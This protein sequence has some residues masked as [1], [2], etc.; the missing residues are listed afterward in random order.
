LNLYVEGVHATVFAHIQRCPLFAP[1]KF[2]FSWVWLVHK[3]PN[4]VEKPNPRFAQDRRA[5]G[6]RVAPGLTQAAPIASNSGLFAAAPHRHSPLAGAA[7]RA[8]GPRPRAA[9]TI[10][11]AAHRFQAGILIMATKRTYQPSVVKRKRTHGFLVRMRTRGGRAV[12]RA[13]RAKGRKRLAA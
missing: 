7:A 3:H 11:R 2:F 9:C 4:T 6:H 12:I 13:R 1:G 8:C 5:L 10:F